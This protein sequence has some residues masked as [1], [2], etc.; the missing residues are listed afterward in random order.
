[1][2]IWKDGVHIHYSGNNSKQHRVGNISSTWN[3]KYE[4]SIAHQVECQEGIWSFL[5][6]GREIL[7]GEKSL[8]VL[9]TS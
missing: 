9:Q 3:V 8:G 7:P 5:E 2:G 6:F 1:M 4:M